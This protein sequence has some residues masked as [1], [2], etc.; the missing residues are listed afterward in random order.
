[1]EPTRSFRET[2]KKYSQSL[3]RDFNL[4]QLGC[5]DGLMADPISKIAQ[6]EGW[7]RAYMVDAM[8]V[9]LEMC[10]HNYNVMIPNNNFSYLHAGVDTFEDMKR[11]GHNQKK[12]FSIVPEVLLHKEVHLDGHI[13]LMMGT[14]SF[15]HGPEGTPV[16]VPGDNLLNYLRGVSSFDY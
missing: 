9:Y 16:P 11:V 6:E 4:I 2:I 15:Y 5:N 1:M 12:F 14:E 7:T 8:E 3:D 10:H 13:W